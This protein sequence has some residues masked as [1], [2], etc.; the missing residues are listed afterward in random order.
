MAYEG[1]IFYAGCGKTTVRPIDANT[2]YPPTATSGQP[3]GFNITMDLGEKGIVQAELHDGL[4]TFVAGTEY[5]RWIGDIHGTVAGE[6]L[7][8]IAHYEFMN[9]NF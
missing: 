7:S 3:G 4:L 9:N 1:E 8:G 2:T 5:T 6:A